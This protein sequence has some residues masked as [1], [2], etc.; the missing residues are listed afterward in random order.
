M[1]AD[2][3]SGRTS[4]IR[5]EVGR[6]WEARQRLW[7]EALAGVE[8]RDKT[9][10]DA[11]TGEGHFTLFLAQQRPAALVSITAAEDEVAPAI[12]RLGHWSPRVEFR[13]AD[14][15]DLRAIGS[16]S[17]DFVGAD[18]LIAAAACYSPF[19]EVD[20]VR[21]LHRVLRPGGR[22]LFTGWEADPAPASPTEARMRRLS[23]LREAIHLLAGRRGFREHPAEWVRRR[24]EE[25]GAPV[26]RIVRIP[27]VHHNFLWFVDSVREAARGVG[28]AALACEL[29]RQ[30]DL[31]EAELA[32]D[33]AFQAGV[34][35]GRLFGVVAC[36]V[37][38]GILLEKP[39]S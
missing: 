19:R 32:N 13:I 33:S 9:V 1:N 5:V 16:N 14:L 21:E 27:D 24:L 7:R 20:V 17:F 4:S 12:E 26:E 30:V 6:R 8:L 25:V 22:V 38:G 35:F 3:P 39:S 36:K 37:E 18:F 29:G 31:L 2:G 11:G 28:P 34:T 10:L 15:S 23:V